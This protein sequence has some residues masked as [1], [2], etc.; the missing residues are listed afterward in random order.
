M[1]GSNSVSS[2]ETLA[3][4]YMLACVH[5]TAGQSSTIAVIPQEPH[6][7]YETRVSPAWN[8]SSRL[9]WAALKPQRSSCLYLPSA[10]ISSTHYAT[11]VSIDVSSGV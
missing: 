3:C 2:H 9:G 1:L 8:S 6:F 5:V 10:G 11:P 4:A 7:F